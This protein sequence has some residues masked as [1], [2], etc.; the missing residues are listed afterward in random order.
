MTNSSPNKSFVDSAKNSAKKL[1]KEKKRKSE[2]EVLR[3]A[4][5]NTQALMM[6]LLHEN[7]IADT[8]AVLCLMRL[9]I[10]LKNI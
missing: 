1:E 3:D 9:M 5:L 4:K 6:E 7:H 2:E 8:M 10:F